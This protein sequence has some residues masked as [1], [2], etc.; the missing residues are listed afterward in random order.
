M[1]QRGARAE[2][3]AQPQLRHARR[4]GEDFADARGCPGLSRRAGPHRASDA[5]GQFSKSPG[6]SVKLTALHPRFRS[7]RQ[8]ERSRTVVPVVRELAPQGFAQADV[9][10]TD[11]RRRGSRLELQT[12]VFEALSRGGSVR[13]GWEARDG[14]PGA[15]EARRPASMAVGAAGR[16]AQA[17][18]PAGQRAYWDA[19]IKVAPGRPASPVMQLPTGSFATDI[20][21]LA[22][23]KV[24]RR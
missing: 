12:D 14:D 18:V 7:P 10:F 24:S 8:T 5:E 2:G 23:A 22:C 13:D 19:G 6:I 11:R 4:S 20:S 16:T 21:Y 1:K 3:G 17:D 9:R 15:T